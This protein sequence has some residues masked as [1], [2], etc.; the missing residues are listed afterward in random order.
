MCQLAF[1]EHAKTTISD[2]ERQVFQEKLANTAFSSS[3]ANNIRVGTADILSFLTSN[4]PTSSFTLCLGGDAYADI[5]G[6]KWKRVEDIMRMTDGVVVIDR[7]I[8]GEDGVG[9][10]CLSINQKLLGE[11]SGTGN[12]KE[13]FSFPAKQIYK[14]DNLSSISSTQARSTAS[15]AELCSIVGERVARHIKEN[16]LF[17]W[18]SEDGETKGIPGIGGS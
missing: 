4:E 2:V 1:L 3:D 16:N 11:S 7:M 5:C 9:V 12:A 10:G 13:V 6:G 15:F 14:I 18:G 8:E 17:G